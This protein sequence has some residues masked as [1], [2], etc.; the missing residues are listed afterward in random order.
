MSRRAAVWVLLLAGVARSGEPPPPLQVRLAG[1]PAEWRLHGAAPIGSA[2]ARDGDL[3]RMRTGGDLTW[4]VAPGERDLELVRV[5]E[6]FVWR[7][8][9]EPVPF[10]ARVYLDRRDRKAEPVLGG[11]LLALDAAQRKHLRLVRVAAWNEQVAAAVAELDLERCRILLD[12]EAL[13]QPGANWAADLAVP[14]LPAGTRH[15]AVRCRTWVEG[16]KLDLAALT[17]LQDLSTLELDFPHQAVG[18]WSPL[19]GLRSLRTLIVSGGPT[20]LSL[21]AG[22]KELR[23][24]EVLGCRATD[25]TPLAGLPALERV[26]LWAVP[27]RSL[28]PLSALPA[29][30]SLGAP[31]SWVE[32]LPAEGFAALRELDL[33][34]TLVEEELATRF[35]AAHPECRVRCSWNALFA[36]ETRGVDRVRVRSGGTCHRQLEAERTLLELTGDEVA[37]FLAA[38]EVVEKPAPEQLQRLRQETLGRHDADG[39][40]KLSAEE[41]PAEVAARLG[42][43]RADGL[44]EARLLQVARRLAGRGTHCQCCGDPSFELYRKGERVAT[45][46]FHH[47]ESLRWPGVWPSDRTLTPASRDA[48]SKLVSRAGGA[49]G[50]RPPPVFEGPR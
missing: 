46:G 7:R 44:D 4:A 36:A 14:P 13:Q 22:M 8:G 2:A 37:A 39:D 24:L 33:M 12:R 23:V 6:T 32:E 10:D 27:A 1:E 40:G 35:R 15:L 20:D 28:A 31:L 11:E 48:L 5:G 17:A 42:I 50:Q 26:V 49:P 30:A 18:D 34:G 3:V 9:G 21:L 25:L 38:V 29:L 47:A 16:Q 41:L 45:L 43:E 19:S